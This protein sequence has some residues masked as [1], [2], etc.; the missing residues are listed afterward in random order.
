MTSSAKRAI[1]PLLFGAIFWL[2]CSESP[3]PQPGALTPPAVPDPT[4][5]QFHIAILEEGNGPMPKAT[6]TVRVHYHGSFP[7]GTI[8]DSTIESDQ[9]FTVALNRVIP[10]WTH[11]LQRVKVGSKVRLVCPP[12]MAYGAQGAGTT[13][14]PNATL[15]FDIELIAI[16]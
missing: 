11:G 15:H 10:C 3:S 4:P 13:V 9:P 5:A 8:F 12:E 16:E 7:D 6:D 14:P 2:A 1:A